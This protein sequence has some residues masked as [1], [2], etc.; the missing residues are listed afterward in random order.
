MSYYNIIHAGYTVKQV[1]PSQ[2]LHYQSSNT[3]GHVH[4]GCYYTS[5]QRS[6]QTMRLQGV[7]ASLA[8]YTQSSGSRVLLHHKPRNTISHV[9]SRCHYTMNQVTLLVKQTLGVTTSLAR[10]TLVKCF[11]DVTAPLAKEHHRPCGSGV[12]L[13]DCQVKPL[14]KWTQDVSISLARSVFHRINLLGYYLAKS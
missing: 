4:P 14:V 7:T 6:P 5:S 1:D 9:A 10:C 12:L 3:I 2:L 8:R 11:Q 13:H